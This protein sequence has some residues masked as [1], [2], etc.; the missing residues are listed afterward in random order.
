MAAMTVT[1]TTAMAI[2]SAVSNFLDTPK[3][4]QFPRY[5][6]RSML[7]TKVAEIARKKRSMSFSSIPE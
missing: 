4:G 5:W 3:K 1:K 2:P 6:A 7:L